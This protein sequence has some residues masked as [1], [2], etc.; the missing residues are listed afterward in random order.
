MA[1]S[2]LDKRIAVL[3]VPALGALLVEPLYNLTDTA[4]V[5]HL[6]R[7]PLGALAVATAILNVVV[8][9]CGF[10]SMATAPRVAYLRGAG[11]PV[12]AAKA[13]GAAYWVATV[14]GAFLAVVI[15]LSASPL[16]AVAGAH[17]AIHHQAVAYIR[18]AAVGIPFVLC[19]LAGNGHLRGLADTKTPLV[20]TL[21]SNVVNVVAEV[22]LVYG[23][24]TGLVGSALG[25]VL[26]Q[27]LGAVIFVAVSYRGNGL[28]WWTATPD[29]AELRRL[30]SAAGVLIVRT[31]VLLMAWS[32]STVV[33]ARLGTAP[34]GGHQIALQVWFL[35]ALSLDALAVPAQI[36]VGE[37][38]G[39]AGPN[40]AEGVA[41]TVLRAGIV[42]GVGLG[43]IMAA[44]SPILPEIFTA[45]HAVR[46]QATLA[47]AVGAVAIPFAAVAFELDGVLLGSGDIRYLRRTMIVAL[48]GFLPLAA[49]TLADHRLGVVGIWS[50]IVAWMGARAVVLLRRWRSGRW[51]NASPVR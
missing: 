7:T 10:L 48:I 29:R 11:D 26:A 19:I 25:T 44:A 24:G 18:V 16:A 38:L 15:G 9:G 2:R 8:L 6:G 28:R 35:L 51:L 43:V 39:A 1:L 50:A 20:I 33:A 5:G 21:A 12:R 36:L 46:H 22:V 13:A 34:L 4:I 40:E 41:R 31:L 17:G 27:V 42:V 45:D 47:L 23:L 3:A 14:F 32:G 49:A 30:V 37:A